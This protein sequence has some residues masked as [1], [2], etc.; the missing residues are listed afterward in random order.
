MQGVITGLILIGGGS[1]GFYLLVKT[2]KAAK[3]EVVDAY[4]AKTIELQLQLEDVRREKESLAKQV[5]A[6]EEAEQQRQ[7]RYEEK[8]NRVNTAYEQMEKERARVIKEKEAAQQLDLQ[9]LKETWTR[10]EETIKEKMKLICQ[11]HG[12]DY[13]DKEQFPFKGKPD[14]AVKICD[15]IIVFDSKSPDGEDLSN[16]PSYIRNQA[17]A[18]DKYAKN[19]GVK[20]DIFLV[21]PTTAAH[22]ISEKY[23]DHGN[24]RVH[25]ITEDA[26]E[27]IL[28]SLKRLEN[29]EFA[30]KLSPEDREK[31]VTTIGKMA[32]GMKRRIQI[33]YFFMNQFISVLSDAEN[34][35]TAILEEAQKVER[36]SKL[37]PP[38]ERRAKLIEKKEI[39]KETEKWVGKAHSQDINLE[40]RADIIESVPLHIV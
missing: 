40:V 28:I 26:L 1:I 37:N 22:A 3:D 31:I 7:E 21:I 25:V 9:K 5:A 18:S 17:E 15:E 14:N 23:R 35:P 33:D 32:H 4:K 12:I 27:P 30:E 11:R 39:V 10:H 38:L 20:N 24:Y 13:I 16:F 2:L 6:F 19:D 29:Y 36:A 8:I 34:L